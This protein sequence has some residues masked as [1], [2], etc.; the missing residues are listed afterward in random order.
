MHP[1]MH[2]CITVLILLPSVR[3]SCLPSVRASVRPFFLGATHH[4][5]L[6]SSR[7]V[8]PR[9]IKIGLNGI[10]SHGACGPKMKHAEEST[11]GFC[12]RQ[13]YRCALGPPPSSFFRATKQAKGRGNDRNDLFFLRERSSEAIARSLFRWDCRSEAGSRR[14]RI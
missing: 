5:S 4:G 6:D 1:T 7:C 10:A 3:R 14:L 8:I 2:T 11:R 9:T 13:S 12:M